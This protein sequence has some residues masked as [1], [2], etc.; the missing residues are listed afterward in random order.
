[1]LLKIFKFLAILIL[2]LG[3]IILFYLTAY[4]LT[5]LILGLAS[6]FI[7]YMIISGEFDG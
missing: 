5:P 1:M 7:F 3:L 4:I 2:I 6:I